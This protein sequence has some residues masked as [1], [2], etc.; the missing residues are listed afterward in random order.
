MCDG[1]SELVREREAIFLTTLEPDIQV[2]DPADT[3]LAPDDLRPDAVARART[4]V[5]ER[6]RAFE[7]RINEKLNR[8][9]EA[10]EKLRTRQ[11][12][13]LALRLERSRQAETFK[14]AREERGR[15][16]IE[17]TF[18]E[19]LKWIEDT[20]TTEPQPYIKVVCVMTG[21]PAGP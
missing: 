3:R 19:Y 9:L 12:R 6:R 14:R 1:V 11:L 15:R 7:E 13:Q 16:D 17:A 4:W 5:V 18:D 21:T 2:L 20:M 8:E 10:L